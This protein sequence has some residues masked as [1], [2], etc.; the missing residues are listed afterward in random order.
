MT[1]QEL[2]AK[3]DQHI[4]NN[5]EVRIRGGITNE[6][7]KDIIQYLL[8]QLAAGQMP[9]TN[10]GSSD[11]EV[12]DGAPATRTIDFKLWQLLFANLNQFVIEFA[13]LNGQAVSPA[14]AIFQGDG[15]VLAT[16]GSSGEMW[17]TFGEE[18]IRDVLNSG[19]G[20]RL[21]SVDEDGYHQANYSVIPNGFVGPA[22]SIGA[23]WQNRAYVGPTVAA[24]P[25][26]EYYDD[27]YYYRCMAPN[28]FI[29]I[30]RV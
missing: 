1:I 7:L 4:K 26:Q 29:R 6:S 18:G 19:A 28:V 9:D 30:A 15:Q 13:R 8:T 23:N 2:Y 16:M 25:G 14:H 20:E 17:Q 24:E 10:L 3:I 12:P 5:P 22:L 21:L 27:L 11:L